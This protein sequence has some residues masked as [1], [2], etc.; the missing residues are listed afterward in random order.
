MFNIR[1]WYI[2]W[3][4]LYWIV[5]KCFDVKL[6]KFYADILIHVHTLQLYIHVHALYNLIILFFS[7]WEWLWLERSYISK[8]WTI[9]RSIQWPGFETYLGT[10]WTFGSLH[11]LDWPSQ[12]HCRF[13]WYQHHKWGSNRTIQTPAEAAT[14]TRCVD[15]C[16]H[17]QVRGHCTGE[18]P[19]ASF[20]CVQRKSL[21]FAKGSPS[22]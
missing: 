16:T 8:L 9:I 2:K 18:F 22:S 7:G 15:L 6:W 11:C 14:E 1:L 10:R 5:K 19:S 13:L 21:R 20:N 3:N 4:T 12:G 17:V